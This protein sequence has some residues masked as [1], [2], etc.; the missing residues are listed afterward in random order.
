MKLFQRIVNMKLKR[1]CKG[2][3]DIKLIMMK[4][5]DMFIMQVRCRG[6]Y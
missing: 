3:K 1:G 2:E 6:E 5:C 4:I